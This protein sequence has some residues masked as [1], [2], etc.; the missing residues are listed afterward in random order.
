LL[1]IQIKNLAIQPSDCILIL[2]LTD[3]DLSTPREFAKFVA[4]TLFKLRDFG[5]W[6]KI[7]VQS[8]S[9]PFKNPANDDS[10]AD[11]ARNEW[12]MWLALREIDSEIPNFAMFGDFGADN[13]HIDFKSGGRPIPHLRYATETHWLVSRGN[14]DAGYGVMRNVADRI[15]KSG[16]FSGE[17]FSAG[18]E[19]IA[20]RAQGLNGVGNP[21]MWRSVNMNHH[22]S[23]VVA[24]LGKI[25]GK[26]VARNTERRHPI[27]ERL[28]ERTVHKSR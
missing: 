16:F 9:Y 6:A 27:Q 18:D 17:L 5:A 28:F 22:M 8:T 21:M 4:E 10:S 19:F 13:A 2:D 20:A 1:D 3:A 23:L 14:R 26:P 12:Q 7:I 25:Y 15:V 11:V 24:Q